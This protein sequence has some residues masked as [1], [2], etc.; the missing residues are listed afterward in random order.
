MTPRPGERSS[1]ARS[2][3][4]FPVSAD[5]S[6]A[7]SSYTQGS[8][9]H[10]A[11]CWSGSPETKKHVSIRTFIQPFIAV[12]CVLLLQHV[13]AQ[14]VASLDTCYRHSEFMYY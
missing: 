2:E 9:W 7:L 13:S 1:P 8:P 3:V 14:T 12:K 5:S 6:T 4:P 10:T 11:V